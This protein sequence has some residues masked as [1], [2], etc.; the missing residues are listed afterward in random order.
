MRKQIVGSLACLA[1]LVLISPNLRSGE[2]SSGYRTIDDTGSLHSCPK[3][4]HW[5]KRQHMCVKEG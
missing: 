2:F 5:D 3:G 1:L 4:K